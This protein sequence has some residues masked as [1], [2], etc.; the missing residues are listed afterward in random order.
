MDSEADSEQGNVAI[1]FY[2]P[3]EEDLSVP[4]LFYPLPPEPHDEEIAIKFFPPIEDPSKDT[5]Q[6]N[7][8]EIQWIRVEDGGDEFDVGEYEKKLHEDAEATKN[9]LSDLCQKTDLLAEQ[10]RETLQELEKEKELRQQA[11]NEMAK[12]AELQEAARLKAKELEGQGDFENFTQ[13]IDPRIDWGYIDSI[14][15]G[16]GVI[17]E[18]TCAHVLPNLTVFIVDRQLGLFLFSMNS[19]LLRKVSDPNWKWPEAAACD[20]RNIF[21]SLMLRADESAPWKRH[22]LK[23]DHNLN[24]IAKMEGPKWIEEETITVERLCMASNGNLY[25]CVDGETF[26]ALYELTFDSKWTELTFKRKQS[27][28]DIQVLAYIDPIIELLVVEKTKGYLYMFSVGRSSIFGRRALSAVERP[29]ALTIDERG[30]LFAADMRQSKVRQLDTSVA[31]QPIRDVALL[32]HAPYVISAH[33]G[34]LIITYRANNIVR[35]HKYTNLK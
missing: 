32:D 4:I 9:L 6:E 34:F 29:V 1:Q 21:V 8:D 22:I 20:S 35:I 25:M 7:A 14:R 15:V 30:Q 10:Q 13:K 24:Y 11:A 27:F 18:P 5:Q 28:V 23:F 33:K 2:P 16:D 17:K 3:V 12:A 26:T 31:F 19:I